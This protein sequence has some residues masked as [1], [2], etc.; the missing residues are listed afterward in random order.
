M[1]K[2][3]KYIYNNEEVSREDFEKLAGDSFKWFEGGSIVSVPFSSFDSFFTGD[4]KSM[5]QINDHLDSVLN[6][7]QNKVTEDIINKPKCSPQ[8]FCDGSCK[9]PQEKNTNSTRHKS[10]AGE[11]H[12]ENE[13]TIKIISH[14]KED[15]QE[16]GWVGK[17]GAKF[18][19][20][21][22]KILKP[23]DV[24]TIN[25]L[26]GLY[27]I[28]EE[29]NGYDCT[30]RI[31]NSEND[32]YIQYPCELLNAKPD[33][34]IISNSYTKEY[35]S[36]IKNKISAKKEQKDDVII[37]SNRG[38]KETI[39]HLQGVKESQSVDK[40]PIFTYCK[41]NKNALE[42]L[43]FRALYG[44]KKYNKNGE[45]ED[46]Q[47]FTRV[48]NAEEEYANAEFRHALEIGGEETTEEHLIASA[49]NAV[50]R[51]EIFLRKK[52]K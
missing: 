24:I 44:H 45:D 5:R 35:I 4:F 18:R 49:W 9:K 51:L 28:I 42:A 26:W 27:L 8:C 1:Q 29:V 46:W 13:D 22:N 36:K 14:N 38:E 30:L 34:H 52:T 12:K 41:V 25:E 3:F 15:V 32:E 48:P 6:I 2:Q 39:K 33:Y 40:A 20:K 43:A 23:L 50:S 37:N 21:I 16:G 17:N 7:Y 31:M 11:T 19:V 47:N 10:Q